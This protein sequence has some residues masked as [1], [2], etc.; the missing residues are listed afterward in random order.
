MLRLRRFVV[1]FAAMLLWASSVTA[2][3]ICDSENGRRVRAGIF[4]E[5]FGYNLFATMLPF[6]IFLAI[7][8]A[9]YFGFPFGSRGMSRR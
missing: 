7:A 6:P 4:D 3:T 9:I 5:H 1:A 8:A 2:C